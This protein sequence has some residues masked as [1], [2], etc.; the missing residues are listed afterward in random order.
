M[1]R[2]HESAAPAQTGARR[3]KTDLQRKTSYKVILEE[4]T[5]KKKKLQTTVGLRNLIGNEE[6]KLTD[7]L[8]GKAT[9]G[10]AKDQPFI[11]RVHLAVGAHIRHV[12]TDY[13]SL[14]KSKR[15]W[16]DARAMVQPH[17]LDK[18]LEWR[19]EKDEPDA[20]EDILREVIVIPDDDD[21]E[22]EDEMI[23]D[24][25]TSVEIIS[26]HEFA[27][28]LHVQPLD[29]GALDERARF[30]RPVSPE[31]DWAPSVK[32][33]RRIST[34]P[35]KTQARHQERADR[36]QAHR[37]RIWQ[38]AVSRRRDTAYTTHDLYR[39]REEGPVPSNYA[40]SHPASSAYQAHGTQSRLTERRPMYANGSIEQP[41]MPQRYL[42]GSISQKDRHVE[43]MRP[44]QGFRRAE[45]DPL[46]G[47]CEYTKR[48]DYQAYVA[49][50]KF[51]R[52]SN[53]SYQR[54]RF[55]YSDS[56]DLIPSVEDAPHA[57]H[58][59][60]APLHLGGAVPSKPQYQDPFFGPRIVELDDGPKTPT[61]KRRRSGDVDWPSAEVAYQSV[62]HTQSPKSALV[63]FGPSR[64]GGNPFEH[65]IGTSFSQHFQYDQGPPRHV[66]LVPTRGLVRDGANDG[67][68]SAVIHH[69]DE[70]VV[71]ETSTL[72]SP[73]TGP[74][75]Q[76]R[77][78]PL[79]HHFR[80]REALPTVS[81]SRSLIPDS[82]LPSDTHRPMQYSDLNLP[83]ARAVV[84][85][86]G[87]ETTQFVPRTNQDVQ[88][89]PRRRLY[90]S[91]ENLTRHAD[92]RPVIDHAIGNQDS[93]RHS[94]IEPEREVYH[95]AYRSHDRSHTME[96]HASTFTAPRRGDTFGQ[97][98][99]PYGR[100]R[101]PSTTLM[102]EHRTVS[103]DHEVVY[104]TSSP[105]TGERY[106]NLPGPRHDIHS[107][108]E[109]HSHYKVD[110]RPGTQDHQILHPNYRDCLQLYLNARAPGQAVL[111]D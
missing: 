56:E 3:H 2:I 4:M 74:Y 95:A 38:E 54:P 23:N 101:Q 41:V 60:E 83:A 48:P 64:N 108:A 73:K 26:S 110:D 28:T 10:T 82:Q 35:G 71:Y 87:P 45:V 44:K 52:A 16:I 9:V 55:T 67:L 12:Y 21:E 30:E 42:D 78:D 91:R 7:R 5:E 20:V 50:E 17:T 89:L 79:P 106:T 58:G 97:S 25:E 62:T 68:K 47:G 75:F 111:L 43:G 6:Q 18:I 105:P 36:Q 99:D 84:P 94:N 13:D 98:S 103:Q 46:I 104:I 22:S 63:P 40:Y 80:S 92:G 37:A 102:A 77:A 88:S 1:V 109:S 32:F 8:E 86:A 11:R 14:L 65:D 39:L 96:Q 76:P 61:L 51:E 85:I 81:A 59:Q 33:I 19:D 72:Q 69:R 29:Y 93:Y 70:N 27:D 15:P 107:G 57:P 100:V 31:D 90:P 49:H 34:P 24:R 66:E 53:E